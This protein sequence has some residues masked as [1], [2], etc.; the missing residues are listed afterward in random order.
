MKN[1]DQIYRRYQDLQAFAGADAGR[2]G[3]FAPLFEPHL[4]VLVEDF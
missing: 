4:R 3:S 2:V 1:P